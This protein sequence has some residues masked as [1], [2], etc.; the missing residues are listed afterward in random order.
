M[1]NNIGILETI[2][3]TPLIRLQHVCSQSEAEVWVKL[4]MFNPCSSVKDR[5]ALNMI[6]QAETSGQLSSGMS[7]IEATSGN[8]GIGLAMVCAARRYQ[9]VLTMPETMSR[10]RRKILRFLGADIRLSSGSKGMK[11]A[12]DLAEEIMDQESGRWFMPRQ[13]E[14]PANPAIHVETTGPEIWCDTGGKVDIFV[15]GIGTGGTFTGVTTYL[16]SKNPGL[17]A[18]AVEPAASAVLSGNSPGPHGIQGI[19]AGFIPAVLRV[20]LIDEVM[21]VKDEEAVRMTQRLAR[22][23]G[24]FSGFSCGAATWAACQL[25]RMPQHRGKRI[26]TVLPDSGERYLSL[27]GAEIREEEV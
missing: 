5:I 8:T 3:N 25:A 19:G 26:V 20:D 13:F 7:V 14:N 15:A 24:I 23:E 1:R 10:E 11:G 6:R 18:V 12:M 27:L 17:H 4:E 9:L 21:T 2:G 16:K 22:E